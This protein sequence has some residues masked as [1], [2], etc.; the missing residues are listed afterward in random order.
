M[1][2]STFLNNYAFSRIVLPRACGAVLAACSL[3][4]YLTAIVDSFTASIVSLG[5]LVSLYIGTIKNQ[6]V[7]KVSWTRGF[8]LAL[9]GFIFLGWLFNLN[10]LSNYSFPF[11]IFINLAY[12]GAKAG[13]IGIGCCG[14]K[15]I[16][17]RD[18]FNWP[19]RP[20]LQ[21]ME[22]AATMINLIVLTLIGVIYSEIVAGGL[23]IAGHAS[24]RMFAGTLR[25]PDKN[26]K[27]FM[28]E[29][30]GGGIVAVGIAS[31]VIGR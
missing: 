1:P 11:G 2:I 31:I 6:F 10:D 27:D 20:R 14:I 9:V 30:S 22:I 3:A 8:Y 25:F 21:T 26:M 7:S 15:S 16:K 4:I 28:M 19:Y 18:I 12:L 24:I 23:L 5:V 17:D 29:F 13:C